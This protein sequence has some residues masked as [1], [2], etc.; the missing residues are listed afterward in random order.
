MK[1]IRTKFFP[2]LFAVVI[3]LFFSFGS[4]LAYAH[5]TYV[6]PAYGYG[7]PVKHHKHHKK[8]Y[9]YIYYPGAQVYYSPFRRGYYFLNNGYWAF[10]S[11]APLNIRLGPAVN[12]SLG[13]PVPYYY[14]P[15]VISQYPVP[16]GYYY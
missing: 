5:T 3:S 13:G 4:G 14:H 16:V 12:I 1:I 7:Y 6:V 8:H 2:W 9:K 11:Y 10:S 15:T